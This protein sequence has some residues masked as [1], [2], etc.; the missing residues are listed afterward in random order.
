MSRIRPFAVM[1]A[2]TIVGVAASATACSDSTSPDQVSLSSAFQTVPVGFNEVESSFAAGGEGAALAWR[3]DR[4]RGAMGG[5][6]GPGMGGFMGAGLG[7]AFIGGIAAGRGANRGPFGEANDSACS[8]SA[9]TGDVTCTVV[10][11]NGLTV[12][13]VQT[14]KDAN[15][16]AMDHRDSTTD[17]AHSVMTADGTLT[18]ADGNMTVTVQNASDRTVSGLSFT[19]NLR[20]VNGTS[21]GRETASGTTRDGATFSSL[22]ELSGA[23]VGLRVPVDEGKPTYPTAGTVTRTMKVVM[24]VD[25]ESRTSMRSEVITYNGSAT[26]TVTITHDG[27]TKTCSLPLPHGRPSC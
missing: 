12:T 20:T 26:A 11:R 5:H 24:T 8:F 19:S 22:R 1:V 9:G 27:D 4:G 6:G 18:R 7:P 25:G 3:P 13:H 10:T 2:A 21:A 16:A 17:Y 14:F 15:G 23:T